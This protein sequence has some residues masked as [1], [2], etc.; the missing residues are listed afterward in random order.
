[1]RFKKLLLLCGSLLSINTYAADAP[2]KNI[3][4]IAF[5]DLKPAL[6]CYGDTSVKSPNIDQLAS[7]GITFTNAHCQQ[8]VCGPSRA[9]IMSGLYP[10]TTRV[11][12]LKTKWRDM[13]PDI[14]SIPQFFKDQGY[15]TV[16]T[17]KIFDYRS[18]DNMNDMDAQSWTIPFNAKAFH[19]PLS[20]SEGYANPETKLAQKRF[21]EK[22]AKTSTP[23]EKASIIANEW[24]INKKPYFEVEESTHDE[25]YADGKIKNHALELLDQLANKEK[26]FFLGVGFKK[27]HLPFNAPKKYWDLY[28]PEKLE[29]APFQ[30]K[31]KNDANWG[32]HGFGE[33]RMYTPIPVSGPLDKATQRNM[34]HG[35]YACVSYVDTLFGQI[36]NKLEALEIADDTIVILWGDHGWHLGDHGLWCKH[37]NLEQATRSPLIIF[38]PSMAKKGLKSASPV[39]FTDVF[40]TLVDLAGYEVPTHLQG[41]SLKP[42]YEDPEYLVREAALSQFPA[43]KKH[44]AYSIR[45]KR[46]RYI[47]WEKKNFYEDQI[48]KAIVHQQLFDYETD[49]LETV[50]LAKDPKYKEVLASMVQLM[51]EK[52]TKGY[53]ISK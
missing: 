49:P 34:I 32:Y 42:I 25:S 36:L 47:E 30:Q 33:L 4:F 41:K 29:L 18:V 1:M 7:R 3:L 12:D 35:Y 38:D 31:A 27:P 28:D 6:G 48:S 51:N 22:L 24:G 13:N 17:G 20:S 8:A 21:K 52:R 40:P 44:M 14:I 39:E 43:G 23:P 37:T 53:I 10:D 26:P 50:N 19:G 5:D 45:S 46:Y 15:E 2:K 11:W 9:S 16:A